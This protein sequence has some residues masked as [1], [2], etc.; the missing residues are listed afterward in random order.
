[1]STLK[2]L[3]YVKLRQHQNNVKDVEIDDKIFKMMS[4]IDINKETKRVLGWI[5]MFYPK[6]YPAIKKIIGVKK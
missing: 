1:M 6:K 3:A 5:D 4:K 2:E